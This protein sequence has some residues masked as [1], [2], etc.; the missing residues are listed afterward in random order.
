MFGADAKKAE[1]EMKVI[2]EKVNVVHGKIME[3]T[4]G[5]TKEAQQKLDQVTK[6]WEQTRSQITQLQ[7]AIKTAERLVPPPSHHILNS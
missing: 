5:K 1:D 7:V 3:I 2:E 6:Q 4:Q